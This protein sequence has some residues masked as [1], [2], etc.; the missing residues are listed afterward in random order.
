MPRLALVALTVTLLNAALTAQVKSENSNSPLRV[1]GRLIGPAGVMQDEPVTLMPRGHDQPLV[2]RTS[3]DGEFS[4][5]VVGHQEYELAVPLPGFTG[6]S[7]SIRVQER[8]V[9]LGD[10]T[11]PLLRPIQISGQLI[12]FASHP[13]SHQLITLVSSGRSRTYTA[14]TDSNGAFRF[15]G[16]RPALPYLLQVAALGLTSTQMEVAPR[17]INID[18]GSIILQPVRSSAAS[19]VA[20]QDTQLRRT[21][22][23]TGRLVD[24]NGAPVIG[25]LY[26][27]EV[28]RPALSG[29]WVTS[30]LQTDQS[31]A[32]AFPAEG[33]TEYYVC[34]RQPNISSA[35]TDI[36]KLEVADGQHITLGDIAVRFA[37]KDKSVS[38]LL[39]PVHAEKIVV[40]AAPMTTSEKRDTVPVL[41]A[42]F[43]GHPGCAYVIQSTGAVV[44]LPEEGGQVGYSSIQMTKASDAVGW[45]V[46]SD[47]CCTSYPISKHLVVY[48][49][50][51]QLRTFEGDGRAIF[52]WKFA[53]KGKQVAF[54]Q[55]FLHGTSAQHYELRD[56]LTG[57][58]I[59]KWD[60]ELTGKVPS[61][62]KGF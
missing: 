7:T 61:W 3:Q 26:F 5:T 23:V 49:S 50:T 60:G 17:E 62:T 33:R 59:D 32:F 20:P 28:N 51:K 15:S 57:H 47:F 22:R 2:V 56:V 53:S 38:A 39:G 8:D 1:Y 43:M 45:L 24:A 37:P 25:V 41:A 10:I 21:A 35:L 40:N 14:Q 31:G 13:I 12:D 48:T 9:N 18:V 27:Y 16:L 11:V 6:W 52:K 42:V 34:V 44:K 54:Y 46:D 4:F 29:G 36:G 30:S 58:L 19:V 55:D